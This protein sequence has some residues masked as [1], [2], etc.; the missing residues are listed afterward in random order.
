LDV[1]VGKCSAVLQTSPGED[2]TLSLRWISFTILDPL[3]DNL[4]GIVGLN[5]KI[6]N[7]ASER[8]HK[9]KHGRVMSQMKIACSAHFLIWTPRSLSEQANHGEVVQ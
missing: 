7:T 3:L 8:A 2:E 6:E 1:V 9:D 5:L 4:D